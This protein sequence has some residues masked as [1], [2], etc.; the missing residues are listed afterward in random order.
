MKQQEAEKKKAE[1]EAAKL[2]KQQEAEKKKA[3]KE[4]AKLVKQQE[5]EK[6]KAE[7]EAAVTA[8]VTANSVEKA[9]KPAESDVPTAT[10]NQL[11]TPEV[12]KAIEEADDDESDDDEE[13]MSF[14]TWQG[15]QYCYDDEYTL[16]KILDDGE[17]FEHV[18]RF[19]WETNKP[20]FI[21][22][23]GEI[24]EEEED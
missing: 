18:G 1:K 10:D 12:Q 19:D 23:D 4:A 22:E 9:V 21:K 20:V 8:E 24:E 3:E 14:F 2:V 13:E 11:G 17:D 6:K 15:N 7:K 5:V 16:Y